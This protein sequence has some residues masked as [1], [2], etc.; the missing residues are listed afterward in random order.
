MVRHPSLARVK[1]LT[2][3]VER[4]EDNG[5][6]VASWDAPEDGGI[7]TQGRDLQELQQQLREAVRCHFGTEAPAQMRLHFT[8]DPLLA[9][10]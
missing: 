5:W 2:F 8:H 3:T 6:L 4:D 10:A 1:E 7:T 9:V